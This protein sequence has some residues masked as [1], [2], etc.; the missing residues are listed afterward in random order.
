MV[1]D[2]LRIVRRGFDEVTEIP[3]V[4]AQPLN[5]GQALAR[6][7]P[8]LPVMLK[9][10]PEGEGG[11]SDVHRFWEQTGVF[12]A[13]GRGSDNL[14]DPQMALSLMP[15]STGVYRDMTQIRFEYPKYVPE[16]CTACGNCFSV[17]PDSAIPGLVN[18]I[19]DVFAAAIARVERGM[20][21]QHLRRETRNV[22][23]RL[24]ELIE[25]AGES[26]D[27]GA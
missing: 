26:A 18:S 14:A 19:S 9:Q 23:K 13:T 8:T 4:K 21:T 7:A 5:V 6:Q 17:C 24:R 2:N 27:M 15:A 12:Y 1:Q 22:E 3:E 16:N 20:P 10:L 25:S 11:I